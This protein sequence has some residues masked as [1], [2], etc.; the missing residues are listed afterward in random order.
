MYAGNITAFPCR[1][2]PPRFRGAS[3]CV[4]VTESGETPARIRN[5]SAT[6]AFV[7][8]SARLGLDQIVRLRHPEAG[9][10][11]ARVA[12]VAAG[13]AAL[14][15]TL[16]DPAATFALSAMAADMTVRAGHTYLQDV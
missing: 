2:V 16:G 5:I 12:G 8:T 9:E 1:G 14:A 4:I 7:E 6:G 11:P 10:I 15:F 3:L 13:G